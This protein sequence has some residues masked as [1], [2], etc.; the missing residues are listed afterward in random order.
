MSEFFPKKL[1]SRS[2]VDGKAHDVEIRW[3][4]RSVQ[5]SIDQ[6]QNSNQVWC[7]A[8]AALTGPSEYLN[9]NGPLQLGG[10]DSD[11]QKLRLALGWDSIPTDIGF[12]GCL[13]NL[14]FNGKTYNL[15][16]P[17]HFK[18]AT[19]SCDGITLPVTTGG[20]TTELLIILIVCLIVLV[21]LVLAIVAYRRRHARDNIKDFHDDIRENII[22]YSDEGGGEGDMTGYDLSVLRMTP[23]G[24]PL[25]GKSDNYDKML[26]VSSHSSHSK[27]E[28]EILHEKFCHFMENRAA[29]LHRAK[30]QTSV[31]SWTTIRVG[32]IGTRMVFPTTIS[33]TTPTKAKATRWDRS[34]HW[35]QVNE[36]SF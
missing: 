30:F 22:N 14:T 21:V 16:S 20:F 12:S 9:V 19:T 26:N 25:I 6:C 28:N 18:N 35:L 3:T 8:S 23:D 2:F 5:M 27:F 36:F 17:G 33:A 7:S 32:W 15:F 13:Q 11:L 10:I 29:E 1:Q 24:K 34:L 4:P 31:S